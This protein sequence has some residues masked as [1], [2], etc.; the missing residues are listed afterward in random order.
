MIFNSMITN[1]STGGGKGV[2][3]LLYTEGAEITAEDWG[4]INLQ[5]GINI[6]TPL[7]FDRTRH[8]KIIFPDTQIQGVA[9]TT[10]YNL[11]EYDSGA[12]MNMAPSN[13]T[14]AVGIFNQCENLKV[15]RLGKKC[16]PFYRNGMTNT[17]SLHTVYYG[18]TID[19]W[20]SALRGSENSVPF[21]YVDG[22]LYIDD[23]LLIEANVTTAN[24]IQTNAF[25][26]LKDCKKV[27]LGDSVTTIQ[28]KAFN[29]SGL[30]TL[31]L[32]GDAVKTL[33]N[34]NALLGTPIANGTG[35]IYIQ[36]LTVDE[37]TL[38]AE[39]KAATNWSTYADLIKPLSDYNE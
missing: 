16:L 37:A 7:A 21:M 17:K 1:L 38:V 31:I 25:F 19:D 32:K 33:T 34:S 11:E 15:L 24:I 13:N 30:E 5:A 18:G 28:S 8:K 9:F 12:N 22:H 23:K 26:N 29:K 27:V 4:N 10:N 14:T 3:K 36:P 20:V 6:K 35:T 39:Y 2:L